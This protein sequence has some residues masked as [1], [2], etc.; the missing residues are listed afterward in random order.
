MISM[1]MPQS[2]RCAVTLNGREI[3]LRKGEHAVLE[4][5]LLARPH[6]LS[7]ER[8]IDLLWPIADDE[9][10]CVR[11]TIQIRLARLRH[12]GFP[13]SKWELA[14]YRIVGDQA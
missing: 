4:L 6:P 14:G 2:R 7:T 12:R 5:L 8:I 13:I 3:V 9:P 10:E 11:R 1:T